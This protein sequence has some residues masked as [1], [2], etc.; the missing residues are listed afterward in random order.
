MKWKLVGFALGVTLFTVGWLFFDK[1][2][3]VAGIIYV[4]AVG[5]VIIWL[6]N[7]ERGGDTPADNPIQKVVDRGLLENLRAK[8]DPRGSSAIERIVVGGICHELETGLI[9]NGERILMAERSARMVKVLFDEGYLPDAQICPVVHRGLLQYGR[10]MF[11]F[12]QQSPMGQLLSP[13][14]LGYAAHFSEVTPEE[15]AMVISSDRD[16]IDRF[17]ANPVPLLDTVM[18]QLKEGQLS[19]FVSATRNTTACSSDPCC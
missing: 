16:L 1:L 7:R 12:S 3:V 11:V 15:L 10:E 5:C 8:L 14:A 18:R 2:G 6:W 17:K 4:I 19:K 9:L 13:Q